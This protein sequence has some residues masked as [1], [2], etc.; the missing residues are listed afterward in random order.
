MLSATQLNIL[1]TVLRLPIEHATNAWR[2]A[3]VTALCRPYERLSSPFATATGQEALHRLFIQPRLLSLSPDNVWCKL[4]D[5]GRALYEETEAL[6]RDWEEAPII[7]LD[8]AEKDQIIINQGEIF[9]G[10][11]FVTQL[12]KRAQAVIRLHDNYC[13]H[14]QLLWL[15]SVPPS[16]AIRILTSAKALKQDPIFDS[17][18]RAFTKERQAAE[19]RTTTDLHDRKIIIDDR[20]AFQVGESL[21]DIGRKG[22]TIVRLKDVPT[23]I[24]QFNVLW[25]AATAL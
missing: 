18:Y 5:Y 9:R 10:K 25:G 19:I 22:T 16:V 1:R 4:T 14:E 12:F 21:K 24:A 3:D 2:T 11:I 7:P 8:D 17:L 6:Q 13:S 23:H 20:E 15:Y